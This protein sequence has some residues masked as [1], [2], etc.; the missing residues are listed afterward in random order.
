[1]GRLRISGPIW[2][3][4]SP[5]WKAPS[6]ERASKSNYEAPGSCSRARCSN[7]R[8][9]AADATD[10]SERIG[11]AASSVRG[12]TSRQPD[13]QPTQKATLHLIKRRWRR[14]LPEPCHELLKRVG[15]HGLHDV[16]VKSGSEA[17]LT[18]LLAAVTRQRCK[19][20]VLQ[21]RVL[22]N[23]ARHLVAVHTRK[24]DVH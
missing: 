9:C 24:A 13:H 3:A 22:T 21:V 15:I 6:L 7:A 10:V 2:P 14:A 20:N 17:A 12:T 18:I 5:I 1:L 4:P 19:D 23:T 16:V 8:A 11:R